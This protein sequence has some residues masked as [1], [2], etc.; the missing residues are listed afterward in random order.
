MGSMAPGYPRKPVPSVDVKSW[1]KIYQ[2]WH[3]TPKNAG[4]VVSDTTSD[5]TMSG[6]IVA[7]VVGT[8][9]CVMSVVCPVV[10]ARGTRTAVDLSD[11][12]EMA[13]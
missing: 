13:G 11:L 4:A 12:Y 10:V 2:K 1:E 9:A 8:Y 3:S 7:G 6:A 5:L